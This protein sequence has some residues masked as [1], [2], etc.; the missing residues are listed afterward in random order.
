MR[1]NRHAN[2]ADKAAHPE[3]I[4]Y[5]NGRQA[6]AEPV[7]GDNAPQ[8]FW[9]WPGLEL[10]GAGGRCKKGI[11][12]AVHACTPTC[13]T[14]V[15]NGET[16]TLTAEAAVKS[17]RL[18]SCL[19]YAACQGLSLAGV[20]LLETDSPHFTWKHLY[21]GASRCTSSRLLEVA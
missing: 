15:G 10:I 19:T 6:G 14:V 13:V 16:L 7:R 9:C 12:F 20:R 21:V 11:F 5:A 4:Y 3:A 2:L 17:L 1:I 8:S 18:S